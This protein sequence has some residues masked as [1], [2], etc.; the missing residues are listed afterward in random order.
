MKGRERSS[1]LE[2]VVVLGVAASLMLGSWKYR[3][4][5]AEDTDH[6]SAPGPVDCADPQG[7][8]PSPSHFFVSLLYQEVNVCLECL[9]L[10]C[11]ELGVMNLHF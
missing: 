7:S 9:A 3:R 6:T 8:E 1:N 11:L 10:N 4:K 5:L 2:G